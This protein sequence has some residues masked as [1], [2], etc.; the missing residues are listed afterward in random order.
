[1]GQSQTALGDV[2]GDG[3]PDVASAAYGLGFHAYTENY[4]AAFVFDDLENLP[5]WGP[6]T[7]A[8]HTIVVG[9]SPGDQL[10]YVTRLGDLNADGVDDFVTAAPNAAGG[11]RLYLFLGP[12]PPGVINAA[13]AD[14][15]VTG[16]WATGGFGYE[17]DGPGDL[18]QDGVPDL[19]VGAWRSNYNGVASGAS[20]LFS[21]ADLLAQL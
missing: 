20:F 10:G 21:G 11:G 5:A 16:G 7:A 13:D 6:A 12:L 2:T 1:M 18:D 9:E 8:A 15:V 17:M 4:G 19:L 3:R 14:L